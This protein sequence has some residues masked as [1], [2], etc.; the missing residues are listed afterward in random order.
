MTDAP[1]VRRHVRW[2]PSFLGL[3]LLIGGVPPSLDDATRDAEVRCIR[4][5]SKS[6]CTIRLSWLLHSDEWTV[7]EGEL[8]GASHQCGDTSCWGTLHFVGGDEDLG[9][10]DLD[11]FEEFGDALASYLNDPTARELVV[12]LGPARMSL[13]MLALILIVSLVLMGSFESSRLVVD[14][15][16]GTLW[17][18]VRGLLHWADFSVPLADVAGVNVERLPASDDQAEPSAI[19]WVQRIDGSSVRVGQSGEASAN[20]LAA[21]LRDRTGRVGPA[22]G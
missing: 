15:E 22:R 13:L 19:V 20:A 18:K 1:N 7:P 21:W 16:E 3:L 9:S 17:M 11:T 8:Q 6:E 12:S 4:V 14:R 2:V 5:L 10:I